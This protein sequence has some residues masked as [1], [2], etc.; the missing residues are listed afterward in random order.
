[1]PN[2]G[3]QDMDHF[4]TVE[5]LQGLWQRTN[6]TAANGAVDKTT[7]VRWGQV[8]QF[9][10]DIRVPENSIGAAAYDRRGFAGH[11]EAG[12]GLC[13]WH[14]AID[15]QPPNGNRDIARVTLSG[16]RLKEYGDPEVGSSG[17]YEETFVRLTT[18]SARRLAFSRDDH[19]A[20]LLIIDDVFFYAHQRS[21]QLPQRKSLSD[22]L[23]SGGDLAKAYHCDV[24]MGAVDFTQPQLIISHSVN[25]SREHRPLFDFSANRSQIW[26][27]LHGTVDD[28]IR[29]YIPSSWI[30]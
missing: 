18:G 9:Y 29:P 7:F 8:G 1:M 21:E 17:F 3:L 25:P 11:I 19:K 24:S 22:Y 27:V 20:L 6:L 15:F 2:L 14:R 4:P 30:T 23:K 28:A 26:R 5:D 10:I 12:G 16:N 13:E